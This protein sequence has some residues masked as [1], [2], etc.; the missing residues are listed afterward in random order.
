ML[1]IPECITNYLRIN[2]IVERSAASEEYEQVNSAK[3]P[4]DVS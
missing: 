1:P 3:V 2:I 4:A